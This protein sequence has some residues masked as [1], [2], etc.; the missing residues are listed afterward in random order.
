MVKKE[1]QT[2]W[3]KTT[4]FMMSNVNISNNE[5]SDGHSL[6]LVTSGIITLSNVFFSQ[7]Q[8]SR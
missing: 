1:Y 5:H 6:I 8:D 4:Q 3:H 2:L 7:N